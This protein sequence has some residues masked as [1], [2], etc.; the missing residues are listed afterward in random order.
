MDKLDLAFSGFSSLK[1]I[2]DE[3]SYRKIKK[4]FKKEK[5]NQLQKKEL[6]YTSWYNFKDIYME[7]NISEE[8]TIEALERLEFEGLIG[9][10][11]TDVNGA[12]FYFKYESIY[13]K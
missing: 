1:K 10:S 3:Y 13:I 2:Y 9:F 8:K 5:Y 12:P 7:L 4:F 11:N 6:T